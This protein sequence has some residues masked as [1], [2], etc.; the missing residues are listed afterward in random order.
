MRLFHLVG[1]YRRRPRSRGQSLVEFAMVAPIMLVLL[2]ATLDLG[3]VF[4]ANITLNNAARE[5][6]FQAALTPA[7]YIED[8]ACDQATNRVVCRIQNEMTG[9]MIAIAP[10]DIDVTCT[11]PGCAETAGS[12]VTVE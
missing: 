6:A 5:G 1:R 7:L 3:R 9:S 8:Q 12:L 10:T 2:A 11:V 4:Y